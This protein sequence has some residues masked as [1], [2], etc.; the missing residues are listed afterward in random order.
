MRDD[1]SRV[2]LQT[3]ALG[4][5][6]ALVCTVLAS[7]GVLAQSAGPRNLEE[8]KAETQKRVDRNVAPAGGLK[9]EDAR[10]AL[11][12]IHS[13]DRDE[14]AAAWSAI[15]DRYLSR[16]TAEVSS[17]KARAQ[18]DDL[19]AW[20]YYS[21][22][23]WPTPNSPGKRKAYQKALEAFRNYARFLDPPME[24]VRIPFEGKEIVGY[25]RLPNGI[26]PA[27][28]VLTISALDS[29]KEESA[30]G[31]AGLLRNGIGLF[32]VDMPGTG[33]APIKVDLGAERMFSTVLD[34]LTTRPEVDSKRIAIRSVSWSGY[35]AAKLAYIER[36]R[37][38]GVVIQGGPV[39]GYFTPDW[40]RPGLNTDE[41]LF[42]LFPARAAIY[43]VQTL[44]E[45]LAYG[46]KLSLKTEGYLGKPSA[47]MLIVNGA[48]DTQ[49]PISDLYLLLQSGG[50]AKQ[51]W[52][53]PD[54]GHTGRSEEWPNSRI[55]E[56]II[57]PWIKTR[58]A[59]DTQLSRAQ[60]E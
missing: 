3:V 45:F 57:L 2:L 48:K 52:V 18:Q 56:E 5:T 54:G 14:W 16:A 46:P 25:L 27:P 22:A 13:L 35:W 40:Q 44:D 32:A 53:N 41:Y 20:R 9:S 17:D 39:D 7:S 51:A 26:R 28:L 50:S 55:F 11:A 4:A 6:F 34:Y 49:V 21:F 30:Q 38:R 10:E 47:P 59:P 8:L 23:R 33:E 19:A 43:G 58:L 24:T 29:R 31:D 1:E 37:L 15:G 42:D 12:N 60:R 36:A